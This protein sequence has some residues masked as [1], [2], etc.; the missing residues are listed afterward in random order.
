MGDD[1]GPPP[2]L[3]PG[4][5]AGTDLPKVWATLVPVLMLISPFFGMHIQEF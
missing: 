1:C 4:A 2:I 3:S 5:A